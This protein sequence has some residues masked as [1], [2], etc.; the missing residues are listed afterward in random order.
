MIIY[1]ATKQ[2]FSNDV[3]GGNIA[4]IIRQGFIKQGL[5]HENPSEFSSWENSLEMMRKVLDDPD[6]S[7]DL[8][9]SLEYQIPMTSKRVDFMI[10][11]AD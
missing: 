3:L 4:G 8:Q 9:I 1:S 7:G 2:Q 11:G 10:G 6:F 5:F